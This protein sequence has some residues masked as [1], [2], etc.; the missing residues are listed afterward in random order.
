MKID[1]EFQSRIP[2]LS[3]SE[4]KELEESISKYGCRDQLV[5]WFDKDNPRT[6][7]GDLNDPDKEHDVCSCEAGFHITPVWHKESHEYS[8]FWH[9][10]ECNWRID[11]SA[12]PTL[13]DGHH[14]FEICERLG[15]EY[16]FVPIDLANREE[17]E[18]WIDRNAVGQR[19]LSPDQSFIVWGRIYNREKKSHGGNRGVCAP[20]S[21]R[22]SG[23]MTPPERTAARL[24]PDLGVSPRTLE[25]AGAF[26]AAV[27]ELK[28]VVPDIE[29]RIIVG[30]PEAPTRKDVIEAAKIAKKDPERA[31]ATVDRRPHVSRNSGDNEWYTPPNILE[32]ARQVLGTIDLDPASSPFANKAVGAT[33]FYSSKDDGLT[34]HWSGRVWMNPPYAKELMAKFAT[35]LLESRDVKEAIVLVNNATETSWGQA[36][37]LRCNA[38]CFPNSRI[39]YLKI[40]GKKNTPL[41][42]QMIV[43]FGDSPDTFKKVF[44]KLGAVL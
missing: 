27:E 1:P 17:A 19:N 29:Q 42:G 4:K 16:S 8:Y 44:S 9:C 30:G 10:N 3:D 24:A 7:R 23:D 21:S 28:P 35:K 36:L 13:L 37:L 41:Q 15:I 43:Y 11:G 25:R 38:V 2:P 26:A 40:D 14:R 20:D 6:E 32:A 18:D 5:V 31:A 22:Q 34:K 33:K 12:D 39:K